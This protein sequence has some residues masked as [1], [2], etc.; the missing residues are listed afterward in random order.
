MSV[1]LPVVYGR[2]YD[3]IVDYFEN[4][5]KREP[6]NR[7]HLKPLYTMVCDLSNYYEFFKERK[8]RL[9]EYKYR[10]EIFD[11]SLMP[12]EPKKYVGKY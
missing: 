1:Y 3:E 7:L 9:E 2:F 11:S 4:H 5:F 8:S 10:L 6:V 12:K